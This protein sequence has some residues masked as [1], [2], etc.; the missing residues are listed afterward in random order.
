ML[1]YNVYEVKS[2]DIVPAIFG[3]FLTTV[4]LD[5]DFPGN[6]VYQKLKDAGFPISE[7]Y[8]CVESDL[9]WTTFDIYQNKYEDIPRYH[10]QMVQ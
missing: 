4:E 9:E 6:D 5:E 7:Q 2:S 8:E 10:L 3:Q 1:L